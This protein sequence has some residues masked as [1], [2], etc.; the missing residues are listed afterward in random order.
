MKHKLLVGLGMIAI[1]LAGAVGYVALKPNVSADALTVSGTTIQLVDASGAKVEKQV[2]VSL[3]FNGTVRQC[4][5]RRIGRWK[6][7]IRCKTINKSVNGT[8]LT[9]TTGAYTVTTASY[10]ALSKEE[11]VLVAAKLLAEQANRV[12]T[13]A[14]NAYLQEISASLISKNLTQADQVNDALVQQMLAKANVTDNS[15]ILLLSS[16]LTNSIYTK[17]VTTGKEQRDFKVKSVI[18]S[19]KTETLVSD[20]QTI[21]F[22]ATDAKPSVNL[23]LKYTGAGQLDAIEKLYLAD[24]ET[25]NA[26]LTDQTATKPSVDGFLNYVSYYYLHVLDSSGLIK[27]TKPSISFHYL[28]SQIPL[29]R[30]SAGEYQATVGDRIGIYGKCLSDKTTASAS[31]SASSCVSQNTSSCMRPEPSC[32][33]SYSGD[34]SSWKEAV[35]GIDTPTDQ[36]TDAR[37]GR[38]QILKPGLI[39][40]TLTDT[41]NLK[42]DTVVTEKLRISETLEQSLSFFNIT[43]NAPLKKDALDDSYLAS[44]EDKILITRKCNDWPNDGNPHAAVMLCGIQF[45]PKNMVETIAVP[46]NLKG[47]AVSA[48]MLTKTG[49]LNVSFLGYPSN[50]SAKIKVVTG[51]I[52]P[53]TACGK[54]KC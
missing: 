51:D 38:F 12:V 9:D 7:A 41:S 18:A 48:I 33:L 16:T 26:G 53:W 47:T 30:N 36:R 17:A 44:P 39:T 37:T 49:L 5:K 46:D 40:I 19:V 22:L 43:T 25:Q 1:V 23:T 42:Q 34:T 24:L 28:N 35:P 13:P 3:V 14:E 6:I 8:V 45:D 27:T 10:K 15:E 11:L 52:I 50:V 20:N 31:A 29:K 54:D 2:P 32:K 21:S 4:S